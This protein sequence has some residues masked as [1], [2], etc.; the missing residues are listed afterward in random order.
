MRNTK[1]ILLMAV[2]TTTLFCTI[3]FTSC[4]KKATCSSIICRNEG[5]CN[6]GSCTC[7]TG[8]SGPFCEI[9]A[10]TFISYK[11]NTFTPVTLTITGAAT[12][13]IPVGQSVTISG[14]YGT[15]ATGLAATSGAASQ[16]GINTVGGAIG[17]PINWEI[18]NNFPAVPAD[19]LI[20]T[21]DVGASY[22]FL[23][24]VNKGH[25]N[26]IDYS[27]NIYFPYG[28]TYE[29]V[30]VPNDGKPYELGYYLAY[31]GS[32]VYAKFSNQTVDSLGIVLPFTTNQSI[33]V[34]VTN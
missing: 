20:Q 4:T 18:S 23:T 25:Q 6:N 2:V 31:T 15:T 26:V 24:M 29:D 17:V 10:T 28:T 16:L 22:F 30:T 33:T 1:L 8:Y 13:V 14:S 3:V 12:K 21:L 5:V 9:G 19:T 7:P 11:N 27:V 34:T 32:N